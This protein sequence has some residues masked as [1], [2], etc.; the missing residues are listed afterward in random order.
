[1]H[2]LTYILT[3]VSRYRAIL[4]LVPIGLPKSGLPTWEYS[5]HSM[6]KTFVLWPPAGTFKDVQMRHFR[7]RVGIFCFNQGS[8][9]LTYDCFGT[10]DP[11]IHSTAYKRRLTPPQTLIPL[12]P[13]PMGTL[14]WLFAPYPLLI[15]ITFICITCRTCSC[16]YYEWYSYFNNTHP[17]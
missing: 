5:I 2:N 1:M 12:A 6:S 4:P 17:E 14:I 13:A 7:S 15:L 10:S 11:P 16:R 9:L 8:Y 3:K